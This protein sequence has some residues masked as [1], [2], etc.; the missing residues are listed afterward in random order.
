[1]KRGGDSS[2]RISLHCEFFRGIDL[3]VGR[4]EDLSI[5]GFCGDSL[6]RVS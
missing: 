5:A 2:S 3:E 1:V 4:G 6:E